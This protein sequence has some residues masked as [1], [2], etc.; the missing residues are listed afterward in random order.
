MATP[1]PGR[2]VRGSIT[3]R[4][5]MALLDL[6]GRRWALRILWELRDGGALTFRQLQERCDGVSPTVQNGRLAELREAA[7]I[8]HL[9]DEGY[10]LTSYGISLVGSL[11]RLN[12]WAEAWAKRMQ[13]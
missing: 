10:K 7:I 12:Q 9:P 11:G 1:L 3:G 5:I 4:P 13:K 8:E 2:R 6:L